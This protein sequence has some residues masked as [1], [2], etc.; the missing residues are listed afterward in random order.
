MYH[1]YYHYYYSYY[2]DDDDH[3]YH[4]HHHHH[5][6]HH[7]LLPQEWT[8][9]VEVWVDWQTASASEIVAGALRDTCRARV[10]GLGRTFG[11]GVGQTLYGLS[12][13]GGLAL[14]VSRALSPAGHDLGVGIAPDDARLLLSGVLGDGA[15]P[16]DLMGSSF[17]PVAACD[18]AAAPAA[19][20][21]TLAPWHAKKAGFKAASAPW[22]ALGWLSTGCVAAWAGTRTRPPSALGT[23]DDALARA[24]GASNGASSRP[25]RPVPPGEPIEPVD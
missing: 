14:T 7:Q 21:F 22:V 11:K 13:G 4:H 8:A 5:H 20:P 17:A 1:Y 19:P 23:T 18:A 3:Y 24:A 16:A 2:Y 9:P 25:D 12:D 10:V 6:H 15:L